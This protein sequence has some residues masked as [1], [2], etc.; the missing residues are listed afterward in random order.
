M[1]NYNEKIKKIIQI[2]QSGAEN[3]I[4]VM[5]LDEDIEIISDN[6]EAFLSTLL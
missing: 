5:N 6:F 3:E 4:I 2:P 1:T